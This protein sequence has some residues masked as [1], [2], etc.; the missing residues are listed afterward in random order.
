MYLLCPCIQFQI[1]NSN[2][3]YYTADFF[4]GA[5]EK[6]A[7]MFFAWN[8]VAQKCV[9]YYLLTTVDQKSTIEAI[10]CMRI[11]TVPCNL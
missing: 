5:D 9:H 3:K 7:L 8:T 6:N 1:Y 4:W 10:T 11:Y 2:I